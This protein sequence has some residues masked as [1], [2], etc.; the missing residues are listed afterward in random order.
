[1]VHVRGGT[2]VSTCTLSQSLTKP[3]FPFCAGP[4]WGGVWR[5]RYQEFSGGR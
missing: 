1:M 4:S 3:R 5:G 2:G